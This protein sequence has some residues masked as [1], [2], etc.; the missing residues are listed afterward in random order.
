MYKKCQ[1]TY[2][3]V[4]YFQHDK[5][6]QMFCLQDKGQNRSEVNTLFETLAQVY[7]FHSALI[8]ADNLI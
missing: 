1:V 7:N 2:Q 5:M 4:P 6:C 8:F 3:V